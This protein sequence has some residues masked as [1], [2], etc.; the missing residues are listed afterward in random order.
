[1]I[2]QLGKAAVSAPRRTGVARAQRSADFIGFFRVK[3][4]NHG[5]VTVQGVSS[6]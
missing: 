1:M 4:K 2:P 3:T 5:I 6:D